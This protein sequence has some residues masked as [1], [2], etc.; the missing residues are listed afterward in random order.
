M[1]TR[2]G[3]SYHGQKS[4]YLWLPFLIVML[5]SLAAITAVMALKV[6]KDALVR[7]TGES[8]ALAAAEVAE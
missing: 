4:D 7:T 8:L 2:T 3:A 6:V 5:L 1:K